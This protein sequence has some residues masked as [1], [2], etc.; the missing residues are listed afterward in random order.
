MSSAKNKTITI[1]KDS[2]D[3]IHRTIG[4]ISAQL[5]SLSQ[6]VSSYL[7]SSPNQSKQEP[8]QSKSQNS[9]Q[10]QNSE[11]I[12]PQQSFKLNDLLIHDEIMKA[13]T[14]LP[15]PYC[16]SAEFFQNTPYTIYFTNQ[17]DPLL[18]EALNWIE[19]TSVDRIAFKYQYS[20]IG[21]RRR[22][23]T[24]FQFASPNRALIL[25]YLPSSSK[26][27]QN[28]EK[29]KE[30]LHNFLKT[31]SFISMDCSLVDH[32]FSTLSRMFNDKFESNIIDF[33]DVYLL[34]YDIPEGLKEMTSHYI[35]ISMPNWTFRSLGDSTKDPSLCQSLVIKCAYMVS[36]I[37]QSYQQAV[38]IHPNALAEFEIWKKDN[39][40]EGDLGF[41]DLFNF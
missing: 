28:S 26:S 2:T 19:E 9:K 25:H 34:Q 15:C 40:K 14:E 3:N 24:L 27:I 22:F 13:N 7:D 30:I 20:Y 16:F 17:D 8:K 35:N 12:K 5:K 38:V 21:S 11:F 18:P 41:T 23:I 6:L 31:H 33:N 4:D 37:I 39:V 10:F 29:C 32:F 1:P 36:A